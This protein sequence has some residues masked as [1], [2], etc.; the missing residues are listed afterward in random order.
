MI[1]QVYQFR[2]CDVTNTAHQV[3]L[4]IGVAL[5]LEVVG[6]FYSNWFF[7]TVFGASYISFVFIFII[8]VGFYNESL[9]RPG[10]IQIILILLCFSGLLQLVGPQPNGED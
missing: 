9:Q 6:I 5:I 3:F 1:F 7:W 8:Q 10:L 4:A 2:H